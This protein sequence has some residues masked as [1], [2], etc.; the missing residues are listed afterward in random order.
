MQAAIADAVLVPSFALTTI[1]RVGPVNPAFDVTDRDARAD[2]RRMAGDPKPIARPIVILSGWRAPE[3]HAHALRRRLHTAL[4]IPFEQIIP[5]AYPLTGSDVDRAARHAVAAVERALPSE[6]TAETVEVDVIGIS[7]GGLVARRAAS[8]D[9]PTPKRLNV[10][11]L[12]TMATPHR[13]A[14]MARLIHPD[15]AARQMT[16]GS[17]F[18][19][20]LDAA[21]TR[22]LKVVPYAALRDTLVDAR[23][24]APPGMTPHWRPGG[25]KLSHFMLPEHPAVLADVCRRLR[26]EPPL[27]NE[28]VPP[29]RW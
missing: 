27:A 25:W 14:S 10:R 21:D 9:G 1:R 11:T 15:R 26:G 3:G 17:T 16:P 20:D 12:F 7:M 29:P 22:G 4:S 5:V 24:T 13:G 6:D 28:P 8:V 23:R 2:L 19:A 18:L